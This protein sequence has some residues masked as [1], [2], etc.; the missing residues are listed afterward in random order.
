[1]STLRG[2]THIFPICPYGGPVGVRTHTSHRVVNKAGGGGVRQYIAHTVQ[3]CFCAYRY[4]T[5]YSWQEQ[6]E[7]G[8]AV[9]V[10]GKIIV[11]QNEEIFVFV[12]T[13]S[14]GLLAVYCLQY[15]IRYLYMIP[16]TLWKIKTFP[17]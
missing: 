17:Q 11:T 15:C 9:P 16:P 5:V 1:M 12:F 7:K 13:S 3:F 4:C 6:K 10:H 14:V 2:T 8:H